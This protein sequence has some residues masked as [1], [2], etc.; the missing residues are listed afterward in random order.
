[1]SEITPVARPSR[2]RYARLWPDGEM[3]VMKAGMAF[4]DA[5]ETML[6][7]DPDVEMLEIEVLVLRSHGRPQLRA[8][9]SR[10]VDCPTCGESIHVE[11]TPD[12]EFVS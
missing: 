8:V 3:T 4:E 9:A 5:R 1:M 2:T 10:C 11:E 6:R 12:G 7:E